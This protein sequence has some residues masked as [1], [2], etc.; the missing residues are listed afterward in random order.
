MTGTLPDRIE[1]RRRGIASRVAAAALLAGSIAA[2]PCTALAQD[3]D[4][5]GAGPDE[6]GIEATTWDDFGHGRVDVDGVG[7][8]Y[9]VAGEGP[10]V[11]L[12][13]GWPQ[14]SLMW[15]AIGPSLVEAGLRVIAVDQ[16][17][18]G[19]STIPPGGYDKTT[20]ARDLV[21]VLDAEGVESAHVFG[22][23]LGA[24]TAAALA[25]DAPERVD[26]L[27]VAEFGLAGFGYETAMTPSP[28]WNVGSSWHLP[29]FA[30]P[31]AAT[32]LLRDREDELLD[33]FFH[34][35]SYRGTS[36]VADEH[37]ELYLRHVRRPGALRAGA[38]Y[39]AAVWTDAEDNAI[40]E[41]RPLG[42]PVLAMGG[43]VAMGPI[44]DELWSPVASDLTT[45]V[46]P[47][48]GHWLGDENPEA[49]AARVARFLLESAD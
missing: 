46:V 38:S 13:H 32:W 17:G 37:F 11:L 33:W 41:E 28:D 22:Y 29:L 25:R 36:A 44:L 19:A 12:V 45:W 43:E 34:H 15:H 18:S 1:Q 31:D 16:R 20:M 30:V 39:Y 14:H 2:G 40:L 10:A 42:M 8:H 48:A 23:D 47:E 5:N 35:N 26:R 21:A 9:R 4:A 49:V 27:V 24:G 6:P 3:S 7:I